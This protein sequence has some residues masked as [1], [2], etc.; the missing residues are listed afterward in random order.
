MKRRRALL[1]S[2]TFMLALCAA[3][4]WW[5]HREQQQYRINRA[6]ITALEKSDFQTALALVNAGANPNTPESPTPAPALSQLL[7]RLLHHT[8][9]TASNSPTALILAC[10]VD[11][12][13]TGFMSG[14]ANSEDAK[15][16]LF[17]AMLAH[18]ANVN[19]RSS[20]YGTA[21]VLAALFEN[22]HLIEMLLQHGADANIPDSKG[23]TPL[24]LA[25][26]YGSMKE[27]HL[28]LSHGA[29]PNAQ[30]SYGET[31]LFGA[32][33]SPHAKE[34]TTD[35]LAH[36]ANPNLSD[37]RGRTPLQYVPRRQQP[38]LVRL[39]KQYGAK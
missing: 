30:D 4:G 23:N 3:C 5:L 37:K 36:G 15:L 7:K 24:M 29:N 25:A 21:L 12:K 28:L 9:P 38:D 17:R 10:I 31:A 13:I 16:P 11:A 27:V 39:L 6:L 20:D 22:S 14:T 18:G 32:L 8:Q 1:L 26:S 19:A 34:L 2:I 33:F 35:L